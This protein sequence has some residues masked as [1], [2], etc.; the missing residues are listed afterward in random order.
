MP[1]ASILREYGRGAHGFLC[2]EGL[3]VL[4]SNRDPTMYE[5]GARP[6]TDKELYVSIHSGGHTVSPER[7]METVA[8]L[9][10]DLYVT[11]CDEVTADAKP[12]RVAAS[13]KRTTAWLEACL[14]LHATHQQQPQQ[15]QEQQPPPT[16]PQDAPQAEP[17]DQAP[18]STSAAGAVRNAADGA[19]ASSGGGP[20][21][22]SLALAA[23]AGGA[24][25]AERTRAAAAVGERDGVGGYALCGLGT[26]EAPEDRPALIA[27]SLDALPGGSLD[28]RPVFASGLVSSPEELLEAVAAGVDLLDCAYVAQVTAG[29]YALTFPLRPPPD[30]QPAQEGTTS[31]AADTNGAAAAA[32]GPAPDASIGADDTKI[33]L[34]STSYRLDKGPLLPGC[35]CF[36]CRHHTRAYTHHLLNTHEMLADVLL[37]AHNTS[38]TMAF[39]QAIREAIS[40]GRLERYRA[41]FRS[42]RS[43]PLVAAPRR[44]GTAKRRAEG[45]EEAGTEAGAAAAAGCAAPAGAG[46]ASG[47]AKWV[48]V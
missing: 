42:L 20:L 46:R 44:G 36:A 47:P 25:P 27:A 17:A 5:F 10:P 26:G 8:A 28:S 11:L 3:P 24:L 4:A 21:A 37:E 22:G 30:W 9:Q 29:G 14:R 34:W 13:V 38:H 12:K 6:S 35:G 40:E 41:W 32:A 16:G 43:A 45:D 23:L 7:Y 39:C 33:N 18:A 1:N 31:A 2:L 15:E 19:T 48:R